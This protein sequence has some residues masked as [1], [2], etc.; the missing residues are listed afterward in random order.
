MPDQHHLGLGELERHKLLAEEPVVSGEVARRDLRAVL[1]L[2][3]A[4]ADGADDQRV[5]DG[6]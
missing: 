6:G 2:A 4:L 3:E 1:L 5:G